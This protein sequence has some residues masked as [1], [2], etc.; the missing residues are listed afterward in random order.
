MEFIGR[1]AKSGKP[2]QITV[3]DQTQHASLLPGEPT[4]GY[5]DGAPDWVALEL[6]RHPDQLVLGCRT[7]REACVPLG[8]KIGSVFQRLFTILVLGPRLARPACVAFRSA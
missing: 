4:W 5:F 2:Y 3:C 1:P 7:F 6:E 8:R